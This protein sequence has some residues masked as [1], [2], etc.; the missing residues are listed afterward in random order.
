[1][2]T[3]GAATS[4]ERVVLEPGEDFICTG[5][6]DELTE[7]AL[8][9][10]A[11]GS[12]VHFSGPAGTGKTTL[13]F[14]VASLLG[15]PVMLIHGDDEFSSS[16]LV[17]RDSGVRRSKVVDNFI[18]SVV[19]TEEKV[20]VVW[21]ENRLTTA[22]QQGYTLVYDEFTRSRAEANNPLL[23]IL[24]ERILNL[25]AQRHAGEGYIKVHPEFRAIFTSN[26]EEYAGVHRGQDALLDRMVTLNVGTFDRDTEARIVASKSGAAVEDAEV[27]V[28]LIRTLRSASETGHQPSIR[29]SIAIAKVLA[30]RGGRA[31]PEDRFF[32]WACRDVLG[33]SIAKVTRDGRPLAPEVVD[34]IVAHIFHQ[35]GDPNVIP[36]LQ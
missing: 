33:A 31:H 18:H 5:A 20:N 27:V 36:R 1:M 23:S 28:D 3:T 32:R 22:C 24:E 9:Y 11:V 12:A 19:R 6:V 15:R 34:D 29:A 35:L 4:A 14:H 16:D 2:M 8:T 17:G 30:L 21:V 13:A 26:P 10:L 25:P 7:R